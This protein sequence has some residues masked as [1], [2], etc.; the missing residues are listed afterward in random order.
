MERTPPTL[1]AWLNATEPVQQ[2]ETPKVHGFAQLSA[3]LM[4]E[5]IS[6]YRDGEAYKDKELESL[7]KS[8]QRAGFQSDLKVYLDP[9]DDQVG[10]VLGGNR[11]FS[12]LK[13][14]AENGEIEK[15]FEVPVWVYLTTERKRLVTQAAI[16]NSNRVDFD[17]GA[18]LRAYVD[19]DDAGLTPEEIGAMY[20][21]SKDTVQRYLDIDKH[22]TLRKFLDNGDLPYS[23][24]AQIAKIL[25][26]STK[27]D[28]LAKII[29]TTLTEWKKRA[30]DRKSDW[31]TREKKKGN[32]PSGNK[33]KLAGWLPNK[34]FKSWLEAFKKNETPSGDEIPQFVKV[35][36]DD[37]KIRIGGMNVNLREGKPDLKEL[38]D[39]VAMYRHAADAIAQ[40]VKKLRDKDAPIDHR[41]SESYRK[42]FEELGVEYDDVDVDEMVAD[43]DDS[44]N[45]D[46]GDDMAEDIEVQDDD[47][48]E[49]STV[50]PD[51]VDSSDD[52]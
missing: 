16:D 42:T 27:A 4:D 52:K 32:T 41:D 43:D 2:G 25:R 18:R 20:G 44:D 5:N 40:C 15:D 36:V 13:K 19:A 9:E 46:D 23:K 29:T 45:N 39:A 6:G 30:K 48:A 22:E 14:M 1:P 7:R 34:T 12:A 17:D 50:K 37:S 21:T 49:P 10:R 31:E 35:E 28:D 47:S 38:A 51:D 11:R 24:L 33:T 26:S 8:I 3:L